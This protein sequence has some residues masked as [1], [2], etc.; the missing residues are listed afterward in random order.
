MLLIDLRLLCC[1]PL[2]S[3]RRNARLLTYL[4]NAVANGNDQRKDWQQ[5][6]GVHASYMWEAA[7]ER[8]KIE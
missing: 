4:Q 1:F 5:P 8:D 7:V 3:A 6:E 2:S